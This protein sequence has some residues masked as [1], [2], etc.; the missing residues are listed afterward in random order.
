LGL[1]YRCVAGTN[2][3]SCT[4]DKSI[5]QLQCQAGPDLYYKVESCTFN[6][7]SHG[8]KRV[9]VPEALELTI[10][11]TRR[12]RNCEAW[13]SKMTSLTFPLGII[14]QRYFPQVIAC[15]SRRGVYLVKT[16]PGS[17][18]DFLIF[19]AFAGCPPT[20]GKVALWTLFTRS[21]D[22][23]T[24]MTMYSLI[25]PTRRRCRRA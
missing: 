14:Q 11:G 20:D 9:R 22:S 15:I 2:D 23:C 24:Q 1:T 17:D 4:S 19:W 8:Q 13:P 7:S 6:Q 18:P 10:P 21:F 3:V 25:W 16:V 12:R 5:P